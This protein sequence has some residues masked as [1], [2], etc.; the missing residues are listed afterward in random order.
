MREVPQRTGSCLEDEGQGTVC[1]SG[2]ASRCYNKN[3]VLVSAT[4]Y[5]F[6]EDVIGG[7]FMQ[8][9]NNTQH[10]RMVAVLGVLSALAVVFSLPFPSGM[11]VR[12]GEFLKFSPMFLAVALA[13]STYG[14]W[15][16]A[17]VG[18][19]GDF[20]QAL[21]SGLG[22]SPFL[23]AVS[24]LNGLI[25]GLLLHNTK[26]VWKIATAV[27][28]TQVIGGLLLTTLVLKIQYGMP[29]FP[30]VY[31]RALQVGIMTVVEI[32]LLT[33]TVKTADLP[34]RFKGRK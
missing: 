20:F 17:M 5:Y 19:I 6:N 29:I 31:W 12:I 34:T 30:T 1:G 15:A 26:G 18:F 22:I 13:G 33:L 21:L 3:I 7:F 11:T 27:L 16:G 14:W 24:T 10:I 32:L 25:F 9:S 23:L 8:K 28:L 4:S 2:F